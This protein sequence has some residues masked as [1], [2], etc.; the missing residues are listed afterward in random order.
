MLCGLITCVNRSAKSPIQIIQPWR[1]SIEVASH[2]YKYVYLC[3]CVHWARDLRDSIRVRRKP[4]E[5]SFLQVFI[6]QTYISAFFST[7]PKEWLCQWRMLDD[8]KR[9][10]CGDFF[11]S[12]FPEWMWK[13]CSQWWCSIGAWHPKLF[14]VKVGAY[15]WTIFLTKI[16]LMARLDLSR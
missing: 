7:V 11:T 12:K 4:R 3:V 2:Y 14:L 5:R 6:R 16:S 13:T 10:A 8:T 9:L 15:Y 1:F